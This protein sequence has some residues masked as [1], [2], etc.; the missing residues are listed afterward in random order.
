[1]KNETTIHRAEAPGK[2][3]ALL[4]GIG[5][6]VALAAAV[7][8][9]G[10]TQQADAAA[11]EKIVFV[12]DRTTGKGVSNPTGD[13]EIF[14]MSTNGTGV[15][16]LTFN[17]AADT[18]PVLTPDG[19]K[20]VYESAEAQ[21]SN[22]EG[23]QEIY[24]MNADGS[25][26]RNL[27][28]N[29]AILDE[30]MPSIS[31]DGK[32]IAY[33]SEGEQ[34]GNPQADPEIYAMNLDGSEQKNL[35]SNGESVSD[36]VPAFSPDGQKIAYSSGGVQTSNPDGEVEVYVMN[37][38]DGS[39]QTNLSNTGYGVSDHDPVFSPDGQKVAYAS[40]G[41]Q[42]SNPEGDEEVYLMNAT[43]GSAKNNL[44]NSGF[45]EESHPVQFSPDGQKVLY[46]SQGVQTS[47]PEGDEEVYLMNR[48][49]GTGKKNLTNSAFDV[50]E[51]YSDFSPDG[52]KVFY[53]GFGVQPSNPEGDEEIYV[54]NALDGT[55]KKNL[56]NNDAY[57]DMPY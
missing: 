52:Q 12:S 50:Y 33:V 22:P 4:L 16:Q 42:P 14:R 44:T 21:A 36:V 8:M 26:N 51:V 15:R 56:T 37:A 54:V 1:M 19:Q 11:P 43:D 13:V 30:W 39:N 17:Q 6:G 2:R 46:S 23:D 29:R 10:L 49:D 48:S 40:D 7:A 9:A 20:V 24:V 5:V 41:F 47:N 38:T 27:T 35:T 31:P 55:G 28:D 32:K 45:G 3:S 53:Q 25:G 34:V 57:D 18:K